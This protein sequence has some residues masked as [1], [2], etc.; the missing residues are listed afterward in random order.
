MYILV[1]AFCV[2]CCGL[3]VIIFFKYVEVRSGKTY[4]LPQWL[5]QKD[6][7]IENAA[8]RLFHAAAQR[9]RAS[10]KMCWSF[11]Y[12]FGNRLHVY[13]KA[14]RGRRFSK[15]IDK[16][17]DASVYLKQVIEHKNNIRNGE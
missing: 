4:F 1:T 11:V 14:I 16:N 8:R 5:L 12:S 17:G 3:L 6:P 15:K 7:Q 13:S 9:G 2:A 10:S